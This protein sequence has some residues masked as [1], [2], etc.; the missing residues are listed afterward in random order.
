MSKLMETAHVGRKIREKR[1]AKKWSL[2]YAA[3][4]CGICDKTF[5]QIELGNIDPKLSTFLK[6]SKGLDMDVG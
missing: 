1:T 3:E 2:A 4:Q 5:G 6:I